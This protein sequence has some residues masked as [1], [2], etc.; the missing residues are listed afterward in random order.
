MTIYKSCDIRGHFGTEL[1]IRHAFRLGLAIATLHHP[2]QVVVGG[3]GRLSTPALKTALV[4]ALV[5]SGCRVVDLGYQPTPAFYYA[6][7]KLDIQIGIQVTASHNPSQDNGFKI[8]L[9]ELPVTEA[10]ILALADFIETDDAPPVRNENASIPGNVISRDILPEYL[11]SLAPFFPHLP[12]MKVVVDCANGMGGLVARQVW[13][14][15][16]AVVLYLNEEID[17]NFPNHPPNPA[18]ENNLI[19]LRQEVLH[20]QADLGVAYDGDADRVAFVDELGNPIPNDKVIVLFSQKA[21]SS[22]PETIVYDQKCSRIVPDTIRSLGGYP[23]RER[24]GHTFI[25]TAFIQ[26]QAV[27]A[28]EL[29]GHHFFRE[30]EGDDGLYAS[31]VFADL[32]LTSGQKLSNL[33]QKIP[34]YPITPDIRIPMAP[35]EIEKLISNLARNLKGQAE[36]ERI[37]GIRLEFEQGWAL[38]R[39]SVTEPVVSLRFE[40]RDEASLAEIK[41]IV[42]QASGMQNLDKWIGG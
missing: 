8:V 36:I 16:G 2:A 25:K 1:T 18:V 24:S 11:Q 3:D 6:R 12:G 38:I 15:T 17:G 33:M 27:Y 42:T 14:Q 20:H 5:Q 34:T 10:E 23:F 19:Q 28:G 13:G 29:S 21:L 39:P 7:Q 31:L 22:S 41:V 35:D 37:D 26:H 32:V 40:G 4:D 9:G 30:I